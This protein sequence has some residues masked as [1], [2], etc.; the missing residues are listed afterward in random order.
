MI[1]SILC[2][3]LLLFLQNGCGKAE[4]KN[5]NQTNATAQNS[6]MV[7]VNSVQNKEMLLTQ[8]KKKVDEI[9]EEKADDKELLARRVEKIDTNSASV[10]RS[11]DSKI[12]QLSTPFFR[13]GKI[14]RVSK[15]LPTRPLVIFIGVD[16]KDFTVVLNA[17]REGYFEL[18]EKAG[19]LLERRDVRLDYI[20]TYLET[21]ES[22]DKRLQILQSVS[23]IK[24]RPNLDEA[25]Q[26]EFAEFQAK[27]EKTIQPPQIN[28][29]IPYKAIFF[30]VKG[31]DLVR[32]DITLMPDG[33][34]TPEETVLEKN[35]LIPYAL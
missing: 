16:D 11:A 35:L 7:S 2:F 14:Y 3:A 29:S 18:A 9:V 30:V 32:L 5:S 26:K 19:L 20:R 12:E 25:E 23:D 21:V 6:Q 33:K 1:N 22:K 34:I 8:E 15:F 10:I 17:N 4:I 31:Q 27:Y 13:V 24:E 28:E